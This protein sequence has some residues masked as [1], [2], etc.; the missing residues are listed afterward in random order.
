MVEFSSKSWTIRKTF[1]SKKWS[2]IYISHSTV[3][4][5]ENTAQSIG[6]VFQISAC[7]S[8]FSDSRMENCF[9]NRQSGTSLLYASPSWFWKLNSLCFSLFSRLQELIF[10][11]RYYGLSVRY[12]VLE[13]DYIETPRKIIKE[14]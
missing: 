6:Q 14:R 13:E 12:K 1:S 2:L 3:T 11:H 5:Q 9:Y 7:Y 4:L 8:L 10:S